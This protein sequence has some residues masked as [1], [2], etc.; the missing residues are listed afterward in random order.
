MSADTNPSKKEEKYPIE[1]AVAS[2]VKEWFQGDPEGSLIAAQAFMA[3]GGNRDL[4][5]F[6]SAIETEGKKNPVM[7]WFNRGLAFSYVYFDMLRART[8]AAPV[9]IEDDT[10]KGS[11]NE[12]IKESKAEFEASEF[13]TDQE[14]YGMRLAQAFKIS[15]TMDRFLLVAIAETAQSRALATLPERSRQA[16]TQG[17]LFMD[18][19][20]R[21]Q[22]AS[23]S[24]S[25]RQ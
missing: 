20:I 1:S 19:M 14:L 2:E 15:Q 10:V 21:S 8:H 18:R 16:F 23:G 17:G 24:Q 3:L 6:S 13:L 25:T 12:W 5:V 7:H 9:V 4:L 11:F 22:K